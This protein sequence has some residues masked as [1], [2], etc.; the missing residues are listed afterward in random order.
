MWAPP[1]RGRCWCSGGGGVVYKFTLN[2]LREQHKIHILVALCLVEMFFLSLSVSVLA[3]NYKKHIFSPAE[4]RKVCY[5]IAELYVK[6]V[7][8]NLFCWSGA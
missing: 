5:S 8:L 2:E 6:S 3:P 4:V 1:P 7:Y